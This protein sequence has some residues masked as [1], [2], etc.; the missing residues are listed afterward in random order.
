MSTISSINI[1]TNL[2]A[3]DYTS[4]IYFITTGYSEM[5]LSNQPGR[6]YMNFHIQK[7]IYFCV[8]FDTN[9]HNSLWS[10]YDHFR[11]FFLGKCKINLTTVG[12]LLVFFSGGRYL[13][14]LIIYHN[15]WQSIATS[16]FLQQNTEFLY[17]LLMQHSHINSTEWRMLLQYAYTCCKLT[18]DYLAQFYHCI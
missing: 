9:V 6:W 11:L 15:L 12:G 5:P 8:L 14:V 3:A 7:K 10:Y 4:R 16:V 13:M 18:C 1:I 17:K 2:K